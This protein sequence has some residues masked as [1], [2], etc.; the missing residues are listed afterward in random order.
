[1][2][3]LVII[4][5]FTLLDFVVLFS[6]GGRIGLLNT[7]LLVIGT[8]M[9]GLH[10]IRREGASTLAQARRRLAAGELP[11]SELFTGATLIFGG[12]LLLAP[13]FLSD[14]L[15]LA[16]LLPSARQL[17][18]KAATALGLRAR[19]GAYSST[20]G[21]GANPGD[22][23]AQADAFSEQRRRREEHTAKAQPGEPIEGD[24]ISREDTSK[25]RR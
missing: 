16:C 23:W 21:A 18:L 11:S 2:P 3:L 1:M 14:A 6:I 15:G 22:D 5:L 13:G 19:V 12:A 10:L 8:G 4:S 17:L 9:V 25:Q 7:L 20:V 24:F